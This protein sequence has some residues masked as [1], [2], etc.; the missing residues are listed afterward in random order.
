MPWSIGHHSRWLLR[1]LFAAALL[2][3]LLL[4]DLCSLL[5]EQLTNFSP[6]LKSLFTVIL[7]ISSLLCCL[8]AL[9]TEPVA[10][11][12][13]IGLRSENHNPPVQV[14]TIQ[15]HIMLYPSLPSAVSVF[16]QSF[17][18]L[19]A[20]VGVGIT[21]LRTTLL[22]LPPYMFGSLF[23]VATCLMNKV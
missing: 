22:N 17:C 6:A 7:F 19:C 4:L 3:F 12:D 8:R 23:F 15:V 9:C 21:A 14:P 1:R 13:S 16:L 5:V 20:S 2:R 11:A 18:L 10:A